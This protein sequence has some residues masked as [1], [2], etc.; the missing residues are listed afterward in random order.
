M[1]NILFAASL[2]AIASPSL[3]RADDIPEALVAPPAN[4]LVAVKSRSN[5][6]MKAELEFPF[7]IAGVGKAGAC[8]DGVVDGDSF[9]AVARCFYEDAALMSAI[10]ADYNIGSEGLDIIT[11]KQLPASMPSTTV[12]ALC[13][14]GRI[15]RARLSAKLDVYFG[16]HPAEESATA[17]VVIVVDRH[18]K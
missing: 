2:I 3:A 10:P 4:F 11:T 8:R 17:I 14:P 9:G 12:K 5:D 6:A 1:R 7:K 18:A 13:A 16:L 15:V